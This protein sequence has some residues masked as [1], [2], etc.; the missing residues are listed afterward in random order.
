MA[1]EKKPLPGDEMRVK[2]A[3]QFLDF[4]RMRSMS[5]AVASVGSVRRLQ[6]GNIMFEGLDFG[7]RSFFLSL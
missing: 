3:L 7:L 2:I 5:A 4:A 1:C 6:L